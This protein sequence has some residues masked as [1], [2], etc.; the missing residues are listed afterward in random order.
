MYSWY[1]ME[2]YELQ[3]AV[4]IVQA[5]FTAAD[6]R[7]TNELVYYSCEPVFICNPEGPASY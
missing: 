4:K 1:C 2:C 7:R 6:L 3:K 5:V